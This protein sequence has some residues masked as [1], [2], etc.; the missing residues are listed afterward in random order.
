MSASP[1]MEAHGL[2]MWRDD[3][4]IFSGLNLSISVGQALYVRG[5]NGSGKTTLLRILCG[6]VEP[7][8]GTFYLNGQLL[9]RNDVALRSQ[10]GFLG[11]ADGIKLELTARENLQ[12]SSAL[13]PD[14]S[15]HNIH[16]ALVD[17]GLEDI[18]DVECRY[19][20]AGQRRRA[21]I[22]RLQVSGSQLWL[23]DEPFTALDRQGIQQLN[24]ILK[25]AIVN[26]MTLIFTSHQSV[27]LDF[28]VTTLD[29]PEGRL[30]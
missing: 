23:L 7:T 1:L 25:A 27:E 29:L 11:H 16:Q 6:L 17:M 28:E 30:S 18:A 10:I 9:G 21:A 12:Y 14:S 22:A 20:S 2:E 8:E 26:G 24:T 3:R 15:S 13:Y 4:L 5:P 19:L